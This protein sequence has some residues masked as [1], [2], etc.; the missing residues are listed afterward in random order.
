MALDLISTIFFDFSIFDQNKTSSGWI[1]FYFNWN[2][3]AQSGD[4]E[5]N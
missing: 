5:P 4:N 1:F 3:S 2:D